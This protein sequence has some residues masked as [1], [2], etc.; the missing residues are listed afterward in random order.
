MQ[1]RCVLFQA[2]SVIFVLCLAGRMFGGT[3]TVVPTTTLAAE[4]GNKTSAASTFTTHLSLTLHVGMVQN[5][6]RQ[7]LR[8]ATSQCHPDR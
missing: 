7:R 3:N 1:D 4:T 6:L 2:V 5:I 8:F